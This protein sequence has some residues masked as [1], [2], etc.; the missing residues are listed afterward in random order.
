MLKTI[1]ELRYVSSGIC[2]QLRTKVLLNWNLLLNFWCTSLELTFK[3]SQTL[4]EQSS[5]HL[6]ALKNTNLLMWIICTDISHNI[7]S[8]KGPSSIDICILIFNS[9]TLPP[10]FYFFFVFWSQ[11]IFTP[12]QH[13]LHTLVSISIL[14]PSNNARFPQCTLPQHTRKWVHAA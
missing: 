5:V 3:S 11:T 6:L 13:L 4:T 2:N 1:S 8:W 14:L 12:R 10:L 7:L 9:S